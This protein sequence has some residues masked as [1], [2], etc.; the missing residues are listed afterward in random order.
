[1]D[2]R[3]DVRR[4]LDLH[5]ISIDFAAASAGRCGFTHLDSGRV[6]QLPHRHHGPCQLQDHPR[7]PA[8]R[9]AGALLRLATAI[10][11]P[12]VTDRPI[13]P[14]LKEGKDHA[15]GDRRGAHHHQVGC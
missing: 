6:C 14:R 10:P 2:D 1:M 13:N 15:P 11:F 7:Q 12:P 9:L 4:R 3:T 5:N 8:E